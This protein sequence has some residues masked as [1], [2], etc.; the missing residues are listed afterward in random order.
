MYI[1]IYTYSVNIDVFVDSVFLFLWEE[2][3]SF[4][5]S[6]W[7]HVSY[8]IMSIVLKRR[9]DAGKKTVITVNLLAVFSGTSHPWKNSSTSCYRTIPLRLL[10]KIL[11]PWWT[12]WL[13][14]YTWR[15]SNS[16]F[17]T[18]NHFTNQI[19]AITLPHL[20]TSTSTHHELFG[21][22]FRFLHRR[23]LSLAFNLSQLQ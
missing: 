15:L 20:E 16:H 22:F 1:Y 7:W 17:T 11:S 12:Q 10:A 13:Q 19:H 4:Y 2:V 8:D 6:R 23:L 9:V 18:A 3:H 14:M 21:R 5:S